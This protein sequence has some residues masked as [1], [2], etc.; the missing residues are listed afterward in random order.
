[1]DEPIAWA[2]VLNLELMATANRA[3]EDKLT[4]GDLSSPRHSSNSQLAHVFFVVSLHF[5]TADE[6]LAKRETGD[7]TMAP[8]CKE[9]HPVDGNGHGAVLV[10]E[11][12]DVVGGAEGG[13]N[14]GGHGGAREHQ[15][16]Q[17]QHQPEQEGRAG[18]HHWRHHGRPGHQ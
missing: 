7:L 2:H 9:G 13:G 15:Q 11:M 18:P 12:V 10:V 6:S 5:S 17:R 1:M 3:L 4:P 16:R 14:S 8:T